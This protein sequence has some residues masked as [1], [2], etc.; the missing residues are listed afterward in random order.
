MGK[1]FMDSRWIPVRSGRRGIETIMTDNPP[2]KAGKTFED[3][4]GAAHAA[5]P[6]GNCD[7]YGH[8]FGV[9]ST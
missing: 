2:G 5:Y 6:Y 4:R 8:T 1:I 3:A 9:K 7:N